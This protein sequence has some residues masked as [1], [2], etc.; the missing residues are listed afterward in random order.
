PIYLKPASD[1][2][3]L[4]KPLNFFT[5]VEAARRRNEIAIGCRL[6]SKYD[7]DALDQGVI[8]NPDKTKNFTFFEEDKIIVLAE[9]DW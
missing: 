6:L 9:N 1:Y 3:E 7:E 4:R 8:V 2:V 5:V